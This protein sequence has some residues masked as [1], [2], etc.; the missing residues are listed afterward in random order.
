MSDLTI[1]TLRSEEIS[2]AIDWAAGE[3]WNPGLGDAACFAAADPH[4]FLVGELDGQPVAT[5]SCVDYGD[6]FSFLGLYIVR[7]DLRGRG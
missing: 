3:G 7:K 4:G 6:G 2:L 5:I 1:R